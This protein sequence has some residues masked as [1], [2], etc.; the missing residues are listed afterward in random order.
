LDYSS[1]GI[2]LFGQPLKTQFSLTDQELYTEQSLLDNPYYIDLPNS[3]IDTATGTILYTKDLGAQ[4]GRI[5]SLNLSGNLSNET[6]VYQPDYLS[7]PGVQG[8]TQKYEGKFSIIGTYDMPT[9]LWFMPIGTNQLTES[10]SLTHD[11]QT[12]DFPFLASYDRT[13]Y[14]QTYGWTNTTEVFKNLVFTPGFNVSMTDAVGNTNSPGVPG[15]VATPIPFVDQLQPK[16]G[17]VYRGIPGVIPSVTYSGSNQYDFIDYQDGER[18][19]NSNNINYSVNMTPGSWLPFFQKINLTLFGGRT[20]SST[21]SVPS[22]G[23]PNTLNFT[24]QWWLNDPRDPNI[25]NMALLATRSTTDQLNASFKIFDVWD[26]RPTGSWTN[27][28]SLL[29]QGAPPTQQ[30]GETLGLTTIY[31]KKIL[32]IPWI[33]LS[34]NSAQLQYTHT[35]NTQY[36]SSVSIVVDSQT[37]SDIYA[38]T[39]PYEINKLAQGNVHYQQTTGYQNGLSTTNVPTYTHDYQFSFE[40]DQKFAPNLILHIPFVRWKIQL[41]D[42]IE[43]KA[44]FLSDYTENDSAYSYNAVQTQRY[45][46][47]LE[48]D[49]NALKNLRIGLTGINEYYTDYLTSTLSYVMWQINLS[50]EAKF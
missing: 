24:Q 36:D 48:F 20:D 7:E 35:D 44:N 50:G 38:I 15:S 23:S 43:F 49:Y 47:T 42:A 32:T 13:T 17:V 9:K 6:D 11:T 34:I 5:T 22:Y 10:Y 14:Q 3:I 2:S 41:H 30:V 27:Q 29:Y 18:F 16:A 39:F 19:T 25:Y 8:N 37:N 1:S 31:N 40:Y 33:N 26:F 21:L 4:F 12:F 46:G 28:Y 45:R